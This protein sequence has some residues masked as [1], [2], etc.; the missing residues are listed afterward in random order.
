[1]AF[2]AWQYIGAGCIF[3]FL[4][5]VVILEGV[6]YNLFG[7]TRHCTNDPEVMSGVVASELATF[8]TMIVTANDG[9]LRKKAL[10]TSSMG[11][12]LKKCGVAFCKGSDYKAANLP[13]SKIGTGVSDT[14]NS[15]EKCATD[16]QSTCVY[17]GT[18]VNSGSSCFMDATTI[19]Q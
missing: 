10:E 3:V 8:D 12:C 1:M 19:C 15:F 14:C 17:S 7:E 6:S 4:A 9:I 11:K 16:C 13:C 18:N 5:L 2:Y